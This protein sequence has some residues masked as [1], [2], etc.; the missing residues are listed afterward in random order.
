MS[1]RFSFTAPGGTISYREKS[2]S[3]KQNST[4]NQLL[5]GLN[6]LDDDFVKTMGILGLN[7][8]APY[9]EEADINYSSNRIITD[10]T[11]LITALG[12]LDAEVVG[13]TENNTYTGV[14]TFNGR[15]R[16]LDTELTISSG[17]IT[18]TRSVHRVRTESAA[19]SDD[20]DNINTPS[21]G[22][23]VIIKTGNASEAI[24]V[25]HNT[26]NI[27]LVGEADLTLTK[28][29]ESLTLYYDTNLSKWIELSRSV[30]GNI[31]SL[32]GYAGGLLP[33][34]NSASTIVIPAG[35]TYINSDGVVFKVD[36]NIT[37]DLSASGASGLDTGSE[38]PDTHYYTY[39]V[40]K[41]S[42]GTVSAVFSATNEKASGAITYPSGYDQK[43]QLPFA[44]RNDGSSNIIKFV[45]VYMTGNRGKWKYDVATSNPATY[46]GASLTTV[47]ATNILNN[48]T[49]VVD[50]TI[51]ATSNFVP[52]IG[53]AADVW[54]LE[55][56][57][58]TKIYPAGEATNASWQRVG[59]SASGFVPVVTYFTDI[60][61]GTSQ[62]IGY[63]G[64]STGTSIDILGVL[65]EV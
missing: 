55:V 53:I 30:E 25:K 13:L 49:A 6:S 37:L 48:G 17:A 3:E 11:D 61:V 10:G 33:Y 34:Y 62:Q 63:S 52:A 14:N 16:F 42:D 58:L 44:V 28:T 21:A 64:G 15:V 59:H 26:G 2:R 24:N 43:V 54:M 20:L 8:T 38:S 23:I 19:S 9:Q 39:L 7:T 41:S 18:V 22:Q 29:S 51:T 32:T 12:D 60:K 47:S 50:T 45:M 57:S 65:A 36:S 1:T 4:Q 46:T 56:N 40:K 35:F 5:A 27:F 31:V